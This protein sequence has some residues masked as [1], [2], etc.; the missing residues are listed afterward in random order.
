MIDTAIENGWSFAGYFEEK[1]KLHNPFNLKYLGS[2]KIKNILIKYDK[3]FII[4]IG[5]NYLREDIFRLLKLNNKKVANLSSKYAAISNTTKIGEGVFIN[6]NVSVNSF[7]CLKD[8]IILN[9]G[10]IIEHG[11]RLENSVHVAPG[12]ILAGNV[13]VGER[14]FIGA[15]S[16]I[17]QGITIGKNVVVGAGSVV[18]RDLPDGTKVVGNP[19]KSI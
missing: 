6:K 16:I 12:A 18:I 10:C 19:S 7:A 11:C 4:G 15:N 17:K 5:D 13:S 8:N 2:E 14:T 9:T 3:E 1:E